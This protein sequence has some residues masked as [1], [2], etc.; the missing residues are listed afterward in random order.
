M[1]KILTIAI[2]TTLLLS[3][4]QTP[5]TRDTYD[6]ISNEVSAAAAKPA[7]VTQNDAVASALLPPVSQLAD[8]LPKARAVLDERFNVSFNNV[9]VQQFYNSIVA[10]TRYNMLINPR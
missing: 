4:C 9:P 6:K 1:Q 5:S 3:G 10:G 8:Q 7:A 2:V